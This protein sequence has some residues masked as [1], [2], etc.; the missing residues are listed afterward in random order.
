MNIQTVSQKAILL[1]D[2][3]GRGEAWKDRMIHQKEMGLERHSV[4]RGKCTTYVLNIKATE[5][6]KALPLPLMNLKFKRGYC[7]RNYYIMF[8]QFRLV[9]TRDQLENTHED[10]VFSY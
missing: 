9:L 8:S 5:T 4:Q 7:L 6:S 1:F 3:H 2:G 10:E